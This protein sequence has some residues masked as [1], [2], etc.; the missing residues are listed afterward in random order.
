[1]QLTT[2]QLL[3]I[4]P[5]V[6]LHQH[7]QAI[8]PALNEAMLKFGISDNRVHVRSFVTACALYSAGFEDT[9]SV[10]T[11]LSIRD[12]VESFPTKFKAQEHGGDGNLA[13]AGPYVGKT[14]EVAKI[15]YADIFGNGGPWTE[16]GWRY[17][18]RG[19]IKLFGKDRYA[20]CSQDIFGDDTLLKNPELIGM[21]ASYWTAAMVSAWVWNFKGMAA[22]AEAGDHEA[23]H[24]SIDGNRLKSTAYRY[25]LTRALEVL[26]DIEAKSR[27][28]PWLR[29]SVT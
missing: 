25:T 6:R 8:L 27:P 24:R 13:Y 2:E 3:H 19:L 14:Y 5:A 12:L 28:A 22:M 15:I 9:D 18:P 16:D 17:R 26:P 21:D 11:Y 7:S 23:I 20:Q 10:L 1:M 4:S 29:K